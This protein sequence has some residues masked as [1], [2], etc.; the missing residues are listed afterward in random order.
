MFMNKY[1]AYVR[2]SLIVFHI[3]RVAPGVAAV[4]TLEEWYLIFSLLSTSTAGA[5]GRPYVW[6]V[7]SFLVTGNLI[8]DMNFTPCRHLLLRFLFG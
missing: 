2:S 1:S 3:H 4:K 6:A 5:A 7:I 8:S